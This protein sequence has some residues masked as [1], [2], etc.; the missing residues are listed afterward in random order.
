MDND[1][2]EV[3]SISAFSDFSG[4]QITALA[5]VQS[6]KHISCLMEKQIVL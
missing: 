6:K 4:S 5:L 3:C 2:D 1:H